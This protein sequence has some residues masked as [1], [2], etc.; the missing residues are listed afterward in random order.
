MDPLDSGDAYF[1]ELLA[2]AK[3]MRE[4]G[5]MNHRPPP[6]PDV[7]REMLV[8]QGPRPGGLSAGAAVDL[9]VEPVRVRA[10]AAQAD[11]AR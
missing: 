8:P 11:Q 9:P 10:V 3:Q 4:S 1:E 7:L 6:S 2:L 5:W